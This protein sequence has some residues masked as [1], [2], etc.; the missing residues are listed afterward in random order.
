MKMKGSHSLLVYEDQGKS[1][2]F[3]LLSRSG[4]LFGTFVEFL[5]A[6]LQLEETSV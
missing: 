4:A 2:L 5:G 1:R 3:D 6:A